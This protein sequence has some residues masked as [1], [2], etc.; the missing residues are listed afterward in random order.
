M[1][2]RRTHKEQDIFAERELPTELL[3]NVKGDFRFS[4]AAKKNETSRNRRAKVSKNIIAW[5]SKDI[6]GPNPSF[7]RFC[8][9][10]FSS[11]KY[12]RLVRVAFI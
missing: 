5:P 11:N 9:Q 7:A 12:R 2:H 10:H 3:N 8:E 6:S 1:D 4:T